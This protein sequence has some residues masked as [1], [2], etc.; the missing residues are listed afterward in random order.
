MDAAAPLFAGER[1]ARNI[2]PSAGG[3]FTLKFV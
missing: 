1:V 3:R 2:S